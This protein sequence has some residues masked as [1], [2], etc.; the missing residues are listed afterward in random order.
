MAERGDNNFIRYVYRGEEGEIIPRE[1]TH[2]TVH[3]DCTFVRARAFYWHEN[4]VEVICHENVERIKEY[5][6]ANCPSLRRV[7]MPGVRIIEQWAFEECSCLKDVECGK[8]EII[9]TEAF[10]DCYFLRGI[11]LQSIRI[12]GQYAFDGCKSLKDVEFGS[13]LEQFF[14]RRAF[15]GCKSLERITIPLKDGLIT[16]HD[17]FI[18]CHNLKHIDLVEGAL[19]ETIA[20][21]HL[22]EWRND[23]NIEIDSINQILPNARAGGWDDDSGDY[24]EYDEGEKAQMIRRWIRSV[25]QKIIHYQAEHES[26]L[27]QAATHLQLILPQDLIIN[28]V[29]PFLQ[30]PSHSFEVED[31]SDE[32]ED[33]N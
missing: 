25:L 18:Q 32:E 7:V 11:D 1:A 17:I 6:F 29:L 27:N 8:L 2:I 13:K 19:H 22:E 20:A 26:L 30:L 24:G 15:G 4:I 31:E 16:T 12:V 14:G 9:Q 28:N 33:D 23:M 21:L 5:A 3:K 10:S